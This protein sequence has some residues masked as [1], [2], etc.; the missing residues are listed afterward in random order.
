M[1]ALYNTVCL[2]L[3]LHNPQLDVYFKDASSPLYANF[4]HVLEMGKEVMLLF[5]I[6][7][8]VQD[9]NDRAD[10]ISTVLNGEAWGELGSEKENERMDLL[11]LIFSSSYTITPESA[12]SMWKYLTTPKDSRKISFRVLLIRPT[13]GLFVASSVSVAASVISAF[14]KS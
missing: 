6:M 2:L 1:V 13:K 3:L 4:Q 11:A 7:A 9:V 5:A 14:S 12:S 10:A 8:I